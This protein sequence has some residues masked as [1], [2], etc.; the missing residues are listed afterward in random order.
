MALYY[1]DHPDGNAEAWGR[2]S[3]II[4]INSTAYG[5]AISSL[6]VVGEHIK[7]FVNN[8]KTNKKIVSDV[9]IERYEFD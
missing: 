4:L 7:V 3:F 6:N 1:T 9:E 5:Q 2:E 8:F